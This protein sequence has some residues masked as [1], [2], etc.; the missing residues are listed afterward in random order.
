V[1]RAARG[2]CGDLR[3]TVLRI[4]GVGSQ[5]A[6][7]NKDQDGDYPDGANTNR[8]KIPADAPAKGKLDADRAR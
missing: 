2:R 4:R 1:E 6:F 7:G 5:Y 3:A 8:L